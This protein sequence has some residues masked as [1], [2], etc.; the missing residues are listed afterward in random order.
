M[1]EATQGETLQAKLPFSHVV[2]GSEVNPNTPTGWPTYQDN[3]PHCF[4]QPD[5]MPGCRHAHRSRQL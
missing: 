3:Q 5:E 2:T 1:S 4:L